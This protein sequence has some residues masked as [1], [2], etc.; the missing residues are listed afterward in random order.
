MLPLWQ[1]GGNEP[2]KIDLGYIGAMAAR[3]SAKIPS[4]EFK[5]PLDGKKIGSIFP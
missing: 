3:N 2:M 1:I 5:D 4:H